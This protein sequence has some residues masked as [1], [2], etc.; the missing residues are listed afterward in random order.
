M[1]QKIMG[2]VVKIDELTMD[3][4]IDLRN[5]IIDFYPTF[6][7]G[8]IKSGVYFPGLKQGEFVMPTAKTQIFGPK[9][10]PAP[11]GQTPSLVFS[12]DKVESTV[13]CPHCGGKVL[14]TLKPE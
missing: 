13:K 3:L 1:D 14:V 6:V 2:C 7:S 10:D 5:Q 11:S 9:P 4:D 8:L 12:Q